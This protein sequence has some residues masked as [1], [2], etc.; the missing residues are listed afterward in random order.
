MGRARLNASGQA[1]C[2]G[3]QRSLARGGSRE[4][5]AGEAS[6][7]LSTECPRAIAVDIATSLLRYFGYFA[8]SATSA[9]SRLRL[10]RYFGTSLQRY[11]ALALAHRTSH[12]AVPRRSLSRA[13][14][15]LCVRGR[16]HSCATLPSSAVGKATSLPRSHGAGRSE[17]WCRQRRRDGQRTWWSGGGGGRDLG[18]RRARRSRRRRSGGRRGDA[19]GAARRGR[20]ARGC[21]RAR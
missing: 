15:P 13:A 4:D 9:T 17:R 19:S 10:L 12:F 14:M 20:G 6:H 21:G 3:W 16:P 5:P 8:T 1:G 18:V 11:I 7:R 2:A